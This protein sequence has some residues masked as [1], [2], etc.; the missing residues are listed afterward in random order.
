VTEA[1]QIKQTIDS[2][3]SDLDIVVNAI[4]R[5][6][7]VIGEM[8]AKMLTLGLNGMDIFKGVAMLETLRNSSEFV[9]NQS[10]V[11]RNELRYYKDKL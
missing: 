4:A 10:F 5:I 6:P 2:V 9:L 8:E 3:E 1:D 11:F 7:S